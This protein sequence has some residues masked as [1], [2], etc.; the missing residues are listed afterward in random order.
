M[1]VKPDQLEDAAKFLTAL[2]TSQSPPCYDFCAFCSEWNNVKHFHRL[3]VNDFDREH[4][5]CD[6]CL[7]PQVY[8]SLCDKPDAD[9]HEVCCS[10]CEKRGLNTSSS[11]SSA[12]FK[13]PV[14]WATRSLR[15]LA[16]TDVDLLEK[17]ATWKE[18][19]L[20]CSRDCRMSEAH[21]T[22]L[23]ESLLRS[24]FGGVDSGNRSIEID[25]PNMNCSGIVRLRKYQ[26]HDYSGADEDVDEEAYA[27]ECWAE[28]RE[29][30]KPDPYFIWLGVNDPEKLAAIASLNSKAR[31]TLKSFATASERPVVKRAM[32]SVAAANASATSSA[33]GSLAS[34]SSTSSASST[35]TRPASKRSLSISRPSVSKAK[36]VAV[37]ATE[38]SNSDE[39]SDEKQDALAARLSMC[40]SSYS[41][42]A[43]LESAVEPIHDDAFWKSLS[44][45]SP[46]TK[47]PLFQCC[48][49]PRILPYDDVVIFQES[50]QEYKP[51]MQHVACKR[52]VAKQTWDEGLMPRDKVNMACL[53]CRETWPSDGCAFHT[54]TIE[55]IKLKC[56]INQYRMQ[57]D[58]MKRASRLK[59]HREETLKKAKCV[60]RTNRREV[61][62][63]TSGPSV[64]RMINRS[65]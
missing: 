12:T 24:D 13:P 48:M 58:A 45:D 3:D 63:M 6:A 32:A 28:H 50:H 19:D 22:D 55:D 42:H 9:E 10:I 47:T 20:A 36:P 33:V 56:E 46:Y 49:C 8:H 16:C 30:R 52:C 54:V 44:S 35:T 4:P 18:S 15:L 65:R 62:R 57:M 34:T 14:I 1:D 5:I 23:A 41:E 64:M 31:S 38:P 37:H 17:D 53:V 21:R 59:K 7:A 29:Q 25:C 61:H 11:S 27:E 43:Q 39:S 26:I 40:K 60:K 2:Q 51:H